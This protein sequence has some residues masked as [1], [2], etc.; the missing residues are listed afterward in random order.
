M[1][2]FLTLVN[3]VLP[4]FIETGLY[5]FVMRN[6]VML[7]EAKLNLFLKIWQDVLKMFTNK[8]VFY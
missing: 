8:V 5:K 7:G 6:F 2:L 3:R 4:N 1:K